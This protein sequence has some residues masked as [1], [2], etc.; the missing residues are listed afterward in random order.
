MPGADPRTLVLAGATGDLGG[1][2][3]KALAAE[4]VDLRALVRPGTSADKRSGLE[5][6]GATV[7]EA[8][9]RDVAA[10]A[11]ACRG[12][13]CVVSAL[14]GLRPVMIEDQGRL[15][16]AAVAAGVPRFIP[17]DFSLDFTRT[18]PGDNRNLDVRR[19]FMARVDRAPIKATSILNGAFADLLAGGAPFVLR[20]RRKV[21]HW[22]RAD[23]PLD[24]TTKD[25]VA[26]YT[27]GAA[28]DPDAPRVLRIAGDTVSARQ[29]AEIM[30]DLTGEPFAL[31]RAG[32]MRR[33][34][35]LIRIVRALDRKRTDVFT[36][37]AGMQYQRDMFSGRGKLQ[38]LD[39][40]RYGARRWT[41]ARRTRRNGVDA[42]RRAPSSPS[43]WPSPGRSA[44]P[45]CSGALAGPRDGGGHSPGSAA[46]QFLHVR[47][48]EPD[49][50]PLLLAHGWPGSVLESRRVI[51][52]PAD[53]AGRGGRAEDAFHL[54]IP[55]LPGCG[56]SDRPTTTGWNV[57]R[58]ATARIE[59]MRRLGFEP[60]ARRA[61]T[62]ERASRPRS[63]TWRRRA[64]SAST[65]TCGS[66]AAFRSGHWRAFRQAC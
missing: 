63:A 57:G 29:L 41:S 42:A 21:L 31:W 9:M 23:Q 8:D 50:M 35:L 18:R 3:A 22:G 30:T 65:S 52:P 10:L 28:L 48:P 14:N 13:S 34:G 66:I 46:H 39:N 17:S 56:F 36:A 16:D 1:R 12:A 19:D 24:F 2:I 53:P 61:A 38:P 4:G 7:V 43:S 44:R 58:I 55:S 64:C 40:D 15:L 6:L 47:S 37:W 54:T 45:A 32:G 5:A 26:R 60:V 33:L 20:K 27:A 11:D 62:G 25:D 49:A 51:D 59:L